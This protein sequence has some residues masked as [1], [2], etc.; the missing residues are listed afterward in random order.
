MGSKPC[1]RIVGRVN[2]SP[3]TLL[4]IREGRDRKL[5]VLPSLGSHIFLDGVAREEIKTHHYTVHNSKM[6]NDGGNLI[7]QT[8]DTV[9]GKRLETHIYTTCVGS[10]F[11]Q[12]LYSHTFM[13]IKS[14][15]LAQ[16]MRPKD[17]YIDILEYN[18]KSNILHIL[19]CLSSSQI[20][21]ENI[22]LP[23]FASAFF[24]PFEKFGILIF[25]CF[26]CIPS[27]EKGTTKHYM[28]SN[29]TL[30][31]V[32]RHASFDRKVSSGLSCEEISGYLNYEFLQS[33]SMIF[34]IAYKSIGDNVPARLAEFMHKMF[35]V[36]LKKY[37]YIS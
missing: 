9:S 28:T 37:P 23:E 24:V 34:D 25:W 29:S 17:K 27:A 19:V 4:S 15:N 2:G 31:G 16:D 12:P 13:D 20:N 30:N 1:T 10:N 3:R 8:I 22:I 11:I 14:E 6:S 35:Y 5:I 7:H 33:H 26:S 18:P 36:G 21:I 32:E